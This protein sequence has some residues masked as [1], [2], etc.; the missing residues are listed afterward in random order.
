MVAVILVNNDWR[1]NP[2]AKIEED[3]IWCLFAGD[4]CRIVKLLFLPNKRL[5]G[6]QVPRQ[7]KKMTLSELQC[8][9]CST[10]AL[11]HRMGCGRI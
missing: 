6:N 11:T 5:K 7:D 1:P 8:R 10:M 3:G 9:K 4:K 2:G